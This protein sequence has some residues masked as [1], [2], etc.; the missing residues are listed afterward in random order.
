MAK[1]ITKGWHPYH[2]E[3]LLKDIKPNLI[4]K[5]EKYMNRQFMQKDTKNINVY[6]KKSQ[7]IQN[8]KHE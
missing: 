8:I 5:W 7:K 1:N 4:E 2:T 6:I 3:K